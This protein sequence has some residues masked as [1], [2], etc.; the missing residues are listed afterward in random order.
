VYFANI[1]DSEGILVSVENGTVTAKN[2][3]KAHKAN[4]PSEKERIESMGGHV[5]FG[6]VYGS[7]AVSRSFGDAKYKRPKTSKDFVSWEPH[8]EIETLSLEHKYMILACDGLFDVMNHQEVADM[9]HKLF[10]DGRDA[11]YVAHALVSRAVRDLQ[12]EDNV[13]VI[14]VKIDWEDEGAQKISEHLSQTGQEPIKI[15]HSP[16]E[17]PCPLQKP[18]S[19]REPIQAEPDPEPEIEIEPVPETE[20]APPTPVQTPQDLPQENDNKKE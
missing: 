18:P 17:E 15:P 5:F 8:T 7:L 2:M 1:G 4:E 10:E 13:T 14:V 3:T 20:Q 16:S 11:S 6:R 12:T 9:T 19:P